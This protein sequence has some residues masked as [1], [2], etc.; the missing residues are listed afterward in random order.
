ML[1]SI[2]QLIDRI[3][4]WGYLIIFLIVLFECQPVLGL[5][6]PGESLVLVGGFLASRASLDLGA[7]IAVVSLAAI[8]GDS[9]GFELGRRL[10]RGWLVQHGRRVGIR[11]PQVERIES[12]F[13]RH[14]GKAA[15]AAHFMHVLRSLGSFTAGAAGMS[16]RVFLIFNTIGC[17]LWAA[18]FSVLGYLLGESW[19]LVEKWLGRGGLVALLALGAALGFVWLVR[20]RNRRERDAKDAR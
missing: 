1:D 19:P 14:G 9:V 12:F 2:L 17:V 16:Y 11:E 8:V 18:I 6:M 7:L 20:R 3:G 5:F 4:P 13:A 10:G 15:L